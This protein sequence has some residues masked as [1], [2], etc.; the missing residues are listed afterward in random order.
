[1]YYILMDVIPGQLREACRLWDQ[2]SKVQ[3]RIFRPERDEVTEGWSEMANKI[4]N[5]YP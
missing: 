3:G 5:L 4:H 2:N 1:V